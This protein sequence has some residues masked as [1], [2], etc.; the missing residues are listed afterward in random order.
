MPKATSGPN[1]FRVVVRWIFRS[2]VGTT[3]LLGVA[4]LSLYIYTRPDQGK[5]EQEQSAVFSSYLFEYPLVARPLPTLC[6]DLQ[7]GDDSG[8]VKKL[9]ISNRT[10]SRVSAASIVADLPKE[11]LHA[12]GVPLSTFDNFFVRNLVSGTLNSI[13]GPSNMKVEFSAEPNVDTVPHQ[14]VSAAFSKVGFN[15]DFSWAMFY[16][17][18]SCGTQKGTEYVYLTRDWKHGQYW[19]VAGVDRLTGSKVTDQAP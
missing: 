2:V 9:T 14:G 4:I 10:L 12:L 19:Y 6:G 17:E 5:V 11:R 15:R 8:A 3:V 16:A 18:L 1:R 7:K 13:P